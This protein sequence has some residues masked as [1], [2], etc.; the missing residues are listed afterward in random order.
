MPASSSASASGRMLESICRARSVS[1]TKAASCACGSAVEGAVGAALV[2]EALGA[3]FM[4]GRRQVEEGQE[5][6][7]FMV[8]AV[9]TEGGVALLVDQPRRRIGKAGAGIAGWPGR[10]RP[11]RTSA[12]PLA[13]ALEDVIE[14]RAD[15]DEFGLGGAVEVGAAVAHGALERAVLVEDDAGSDQAGPR[16][17]VAAGRWSSCGIRPGSACQRSL[18]AG[19][20]GQHGEEGRVLA[21][22][23]DGDGMTDEPDQERRR[24]TVSGQGRSRP[25]ACR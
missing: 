5:I 11:R 9:G 15:R 1:V 20:A 13:E 2:E 10:A 14:P 19:V 21:G 8:G 3:T 4:L 7:A 23:P 18:V 17:V 16:Q 6:A 12:Q 22:D 24:S 25:R